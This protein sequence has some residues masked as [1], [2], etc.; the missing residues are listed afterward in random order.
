MAITAPTRT[1]DD[2]WKDNLRVSVGVMNLDS[3]GRA[4]RVRMLQEP[5]KLIFCFLSHELLEVM[6]AEAED[7]SISCTLMPALQPR[8]TC[9]LLAL[10]DSFDF[11]V[12][13]QTRGLEHVLKETW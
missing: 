13:F 8:P 5:C 2:I 11:S 1:L 12:L 7:T 6:A 4:V 10:A 9:S 3:F